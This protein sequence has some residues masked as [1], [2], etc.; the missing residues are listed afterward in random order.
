MV[1]ALVMACDAEPP[2][3]L[4]AVQDPEPTPPA[5]ESVRRPA[6]TYLMT[7]TGERCEVTISVGGE[8]IERLPTAYACPKDLELGE[9]IRLA[10]MTCIREGGPVERKVPVV[11]P[12]YLT[13]VERD[14]R[15]AAKDAGR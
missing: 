2:T 15:E 1:F 4:P 11:C 7:R 8:V 6:E 12:D 3:P 13:N 10:G 9:W 14:R 5:L